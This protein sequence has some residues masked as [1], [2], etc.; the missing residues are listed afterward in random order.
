MSLLLALVMTTAL[1]HE[2]TVTPGGAGPNRLNPDVTLL[3]GAQRDL[4]DL[5]LYDAQNREVGYLLVPPHVEDKWLSGEMLPVASTKNTSGFELDLGRPQFIDR[6]RFDGITPPYLKRVTLEGSGDRTR[7]T[8]LAETTVFDVPAERH[9][10]TEVGFKAGRYRYLR[11]TWD[12]RSSARV[13]PA[14]AS[15]HEVRFEAGEWAFPIAFA[16]RTSEPRRSR[17]RLTLPGAHLPVTAIDISVPGTHV[18]RNATVTEP[19][20]TTNQVAPVVLGRGTLRTGGLSIPISSPEGREL[21]LVIED[22]SNPPLEILAVHGEL[23]PQPWIYFESPDG[24]PLTARYGDANAKAPLYDIEASRPGVEKRE[25]KLAAWGAPAVQAIA[26]KEP[27]LEIPRGGEIARDQFRVSRRI[28]AAPAGLAVLLLDAHALARSNDLADIRIADADG[29][30]VPY[31]VEDRSAPLVVGLKIPERTAEGHSSIYRLELPYDAWPQS[32]RLVLT[33]DARVF[34]RDV[35]VRRV[36]DTHRNRHAGALARATWRNTDPE[37]LPPAFEAEISIRDARAIEVVID[38]GDN[39]P[40][41]I[42]SAQLL[43]PSRALR[44][45]HPG[46]PLSLLYGNRRASAPRYDIQ[47]LAGRLFGEPARELTL[48]PGVD[49]RGDE[50]TPDRKWFWMGIIVAAVVLIAL[51]LRLVLVSGETSRAPGDST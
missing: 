44:F 21:D 18:F 8:L 42:V 6:I 32:T 40:L 36:A 41:P 22:A 7:W 48:S 15:A 10:Q 16:K 14:S 33:T 5:R 30:Q 50:D 35:V 29:R 31:L 45:Q 34:E 12:D 23:Q 46:T 2:R 25:V 17:Y 37:T 20:L 51:L 19:R 26:R 39:A 4:R 13:S 28:P 3:A 9:R 11:A 24:A 1:A 27:E 49:D 38:E 43:L 47:L